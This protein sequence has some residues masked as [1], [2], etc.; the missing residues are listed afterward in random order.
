MDKNKIIALLLVSVLFFAFSYFNTQEQE[1]YLAQ[2]AEYELA[3]AE[4]EAKTAAVKQEVL[5]SVAKSDT[6]DLKR[7][8]EA[9][10]GESLTAAKSA[11]AETIRLENDVITID[12]STRGAEPKSVTLKEYTKYAPKDERTELVKMFDPIKSGM[13]LMFFIRNGL[14]NQ[15]INTSD[16]TFEALPIT[17]TIDGGQ[18]LTMS[19]KFD[20]GAELQYVY[21]LYDS[22]SVA[23][24]YMLDFKIRMHDMTPIMANQ[25]ALTLN[26]KATTY[27]NER[28]FSNENLY[29]TLAYHYPT[30]GSIEELSAGDG[31]ESESIST[32]VDW[33]AFKQQYFTSAIIAPGGGI[34]TSTMAY[35]TA[36]PQSGYI[37][38]FEATM[39]LPLDPAKT[40]YDMALYFGPNKYSTL[41]AIDD[42]GYGELRMGELVPLG[43][44]IFGW[45][46]KFIVIPVF[47]FLRLYISSFGIIILILAVFVKLII[48]P[49]T[50]SSYISMAKM[51]VV[52]PQV[53]EL[54]ARYPKPEDAQK[55]QQAMM[56]LYRKTGIN[57]M[58]G[59]IPMLIQM[60]IVIA[61][62]RFFPASIELR[63]QSF[64]WANDLSSYDSVVTLPFDI[65]FYG[66]H[67]SLFALL[68]AV[69]L[70]FY[71]AMN[72][73]QS[74]SSQPQQMAG[75]KFMMV[76]MMPV[77]M[78]VWF[79]S[80][81]SGLCYYY[82]LANLL[83]IGQ[84]I[85]IRRM[86]DDEKILAILKANEAKKKNTKKSKF[87]QRYEDMLAQQ[88]AQ[89]NSKK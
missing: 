85:L 50:Y 57:P 3:I 55:K 12:F 19:L 39:T 81:S 2:K 48:S 73:N 54:N 5:Q 59:C 67:V 76:Y 74:A 41:K 52:K 15:Q 82:F 26:W 63:G 43:W 79:N 22:E 8:S 68:M 62:F 37:K 75:M 4:Q 78:L 72:Y 83:T 16:Y 25:S 88:E 36:Q 70:Y 1:K 86:V 42:L 21:T 6:V 61:M 24:N 27:Q 65:P 69:V 10:I 47:D 66:D 11:E 56:D 64:L 89:Q 28:G 51:R 84:T 9:L 58:G 49:M 53:D 71:S 35:T 18:Q 33:V 77:M 30:E 40:E 14:N 31:S 38:N 44:G 7:I 45:V 80:Y 13:D 23:R 17:K 60:P 32:S 46:N 87:Q 29:T 34:S 20:S